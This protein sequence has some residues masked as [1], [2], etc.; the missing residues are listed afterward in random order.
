MTVVLYKLGGSLLDLSDLPQRLCSVIANDDDVRPLLVVGGG[1]T[2]DLVRRWDRVHQLGEE[3]SHWLAL[4]SLELNESLLAEL[5]PSARIVTSRGEAGDSWQRGF[6]PILRSRAF[7]RD[8][9]PLADVPL[10]HTWNATSDSI[11]AWIAL[12]WPADR[13]VLLKSVSLPADC[14]EEA[15]VPVKH[16]GRTG[17]SVR[18]SDLVAAGLVDPHFPELAAFLPSVEWINLRAKESGVQS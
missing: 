3:R 5:L 6:W 16:D 18:G 8:E 10:P 14:P 2:A 13:L 1:P 12:H 4:R 15:R 11:A 9:E 7:L 17:K